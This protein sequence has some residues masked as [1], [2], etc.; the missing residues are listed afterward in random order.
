MET[1]GISHLATE[2]KEQGN[3]S[4]D[5]H[6]QPTEPKTIGKNEKSKFSSDI[7]FK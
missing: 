3:E 6:E 2:P 4:K 7:S 1:S 5:D